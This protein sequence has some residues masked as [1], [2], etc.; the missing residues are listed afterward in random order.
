M[1]WVY[2]L[3][4]GVYNFHSPCRQRRR[5][6]CGKHTIRSV[7]ASTIILAAKGY[8][9]DKLKLQVRLRLK[10]SERLNFRLV[11]L[12]DAGCARSL[13]LA[14]IVVGTYGF[15]VRPSLSM[16]GSCRASLTLIII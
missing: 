5:H 4:I 1:R 9:I 14:K 16:V 11:N 2:F 12:P 15:T 8:A 13:S 7:L 10:L 6:S 3:N